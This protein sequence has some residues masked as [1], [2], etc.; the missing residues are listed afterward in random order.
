MAAENAI[1]NI[2]HKH[3]SHLL[4]HSIKMRAENVNDEVI[5]ELNK[6]TAQLNKL[7]QQNQLN[8]SLL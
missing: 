8:H 2:A 1:L 6:N 3:G 5:S 4:V 7:K